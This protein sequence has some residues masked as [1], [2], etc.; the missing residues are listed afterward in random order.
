M[1]QRAMMVS[2]A[3]P[4][5]QAPLPLTERRRLQTQLEIAHCAA[6]LFAAR[7]ASAVTAEDIATAA[8]ISLRT[9]YR[10]F[11]TKEEAVTP[12]LA[13]GVRDW[14]HDLAR[15][16]RDLPAAEALERSARR[17]LSRTDRAGV[18]SLR[19]THELFRAIPGDPGLESVWFRIVHDTEES[20]V[21]VLRDLMGPEADPLDVRLMA[22]A[23]NTAM[24]IAI[25]TW[26]DSDV[27]AGSD[28]TP[29]EIVAR[30]IRTLTAG[31]RT[32]QG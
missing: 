20:L 9:F 22:V 15:G 16:P 1:A 2:M 11:R 18:D 14:I 4:G 13:G 26:A 25:Q 23:G 30:C 28:G 24:R 6:E 27:A 17:A 31:L 8:G 19:L 12:M 10:Y 29:A 5:A 3:D 7:G 32:P 21:E